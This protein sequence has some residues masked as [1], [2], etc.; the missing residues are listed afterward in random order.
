MSYPR[1]AKSFRVDES[2]EKLPD[3]VFFPLG[4][5]RFKKIVFM[6]MMIL[7]TGKKDGKKDC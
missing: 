1:E 3:F 7:I 2:V 5:L 4:I 6:K